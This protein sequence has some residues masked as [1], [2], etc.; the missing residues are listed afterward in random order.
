MMY[1]LLE[2]NILKGQHVAII[3][4][5]VVGFLRTRTKTSGFGYDRR[6]NILKANT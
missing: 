6:D 1:L 2:N 3:F 4:G 5:G